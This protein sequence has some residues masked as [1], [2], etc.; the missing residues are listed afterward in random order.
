[1]HVALFKAGQNSPDIS[2]MNMYRRFLHSPKPDL[3]AT[4]AQ[5]QDKEQQKASELYSHA[6]ALLQPSHHSAS[7][8]QQQ[9][10]RI[11]D[12]LFDAHQKGDGLFAVNQAVIV[13]QGQIHDRAD[14]DL[15]GDGHGAL[16][17]IVQT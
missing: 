9:T 6:F 16:H 5:G 17:N 11:F 15:A 13:R 14:F 8:P 10:G 7:D 2:G 12:Q 4:I 3:S 1:M